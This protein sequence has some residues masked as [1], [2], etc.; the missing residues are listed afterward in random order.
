[1]T[2][3]TAGAAAKILGISKRTLYRWEDEGKIKSIREGVLQVRLYNKHYIEETKQI[4]DLNE[5]E[6]ELVRKLGEAVE[7]EKKV[8]FAQD[9]NKIRSGEEKFQLM[10]I[11]TAGKAMDRVNAI[12]KEWR[13]TL[14]ELFMFPRER[15]RELLL[16]KE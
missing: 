2:Q 14:D 11:E 1:M 7:E 15:L 13:E 9:V 10:D 16:K 6:R 5:K 8:L 12:E 4:L 3:I